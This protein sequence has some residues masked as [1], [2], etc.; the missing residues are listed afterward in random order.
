MSN[1][2]SLTKYF[3]RKRNQHFVF[4]GKC[5]EITNVTHKFFLYVALLS[6]E[7]SEK[8]PRKIGEAT[9]NVRAVEVERNQRKVGIPVWKTDI[10]FRSGQKAGKIISCFLFQLCLKIYCFS[11][12]FPFCLP[13]TCCFLLL[14]LLFLFLILF[15]CCGSVRKRTFK[16]LAT[17][18]LTG[19]LVVFVFFLLSACSSAF[20]RLVLNDRGKERGREIRELQLIMTN[21]WSPLQQLSFISCLGRAREV[22]VL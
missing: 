2:S 17:V 13:T 11:M 7:K 22:V 8:K 21:F 16:F 12:L 3:L 14:F 5:S 10:F 18:T 19:M 4:S 9:I 15:L 20:Q 1:H 6:C